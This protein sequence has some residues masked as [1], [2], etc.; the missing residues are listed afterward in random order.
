M[1][2]PELW[3]VAGPN[4][5]GKTTLIQRE[6]MAGWLAS[7]RVLNADDVTLGLLREAGYVE[8]S[9]VPEDELKPLFIAAAE[10]VQKEAQA[11]LDAGGCVCLESVLSTPKFRMMVDRVIEAGG[12]ILSHLYWRE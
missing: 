10:K 1:S 6:P 7:A 3:I 5:A 2:R 12:A 9:A 4:G 8:F 11:L